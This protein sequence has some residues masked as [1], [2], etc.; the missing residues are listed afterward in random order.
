MFHSVYIKCQRHLCIRANTY[1]F[2]ESSIQ[3]PGTKEIQ[4][5]HRSSSM[6]GH[7]CFS[8]KRIVVNDTITDKD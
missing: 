1:T 6:K 8:S 7:S 4:Q 2:K 3:Q 5:V